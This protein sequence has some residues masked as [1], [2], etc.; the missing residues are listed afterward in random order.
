MRWMNRDPIE[1][2]TETNLYESCGIA[3]SYMFDCLGLTKVDINVSTKATDSGSGVRDFIVIEAKV[4]EAP[5]NNGWLN[6]IQ[7]K[8]QGNADWSLDMGRDFGPYYYTRRQISQFTK[9]NKSGNR[10]V[11]LYDAP[12]GALDDKVNFYTAVVEIHRDC[13]VASLPDFNN[14]RYIKCYDIVRVIASVSWSYDPNNFR[15]YSYTGEVDGLFKRKAMLPTLQKLVNNERWST[16]LCP[17]TRVEV[18]E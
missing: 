7:L 18:T 3:M 13:W 4:V 2:D 10:I 16:D 6:F 8:K 15:H 17:H 11:S 1:E 14:A 5:K 9:R 12:G